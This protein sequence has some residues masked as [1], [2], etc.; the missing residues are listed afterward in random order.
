MPNPPLL[1]F[2]QGD[3]EIAIYRCTIGTPLFCR[4]EAWLRK[5]VRG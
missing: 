5:L 2:G 1:L 4:F 3:Y